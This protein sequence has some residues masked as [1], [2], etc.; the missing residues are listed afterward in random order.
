MGVSCKVLNAATI[1]IFGVIFW[2]AICPAADVSFIVLG[3]LHYDKLE[4]HDMDWLKNKWV[5][6]D[7]YR[8]VTQEYVVYT[9]KNWDKLMKALGRRI[10]G[11][12]G[13][14]KGIVQLGD[15]M[16]GLAGNPEMVKKMEFG[17]IKAIEEPNFQ[18]RWI[19]VKGNHDGWRKGQG[20]AEAYKEIMVPFRNKQMGIADGGTSF[21]YRAGDIEFF[22]PDSEMELN[23]LID[24]LEKG[25]AESNAKFKFVAMHAPVI[26]V[27]GRCWDI[28][29]IKDMKA[30]AQSQE[31]LLGLLARN[32][33]IVLC[34]HLHRYSVV[35]RDTGRGPVIQVML[36]SVIRDSN[37]PGPYWY[38]RQFGPELVDMEPDFA[39]ATQQQR[40][41][42][43]RQEM[44]YVTDFRL[45]DFPGYAVLTI[46]RE[47]ICLKMY[48]GVTDTVQEEVDLSQMLQKAS[49]AHVLPKN[50]PLR[51]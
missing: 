34:A 10:K 36:N 11:N 27:T 29:G 37:S 18:V 13:Q 24:F 45:A 20:E 9:A 46:K 30:R 50:H 40:K 5:N 7:D 15:F 35:R 28:F 33:A 6:P 4:F 26:P 17:T 31:R 43:L 44:K 16:E 19:L 21:R 39:P 41:Q 48:R 2:A 23:T 12:G 47:R 8:Q 49:P 32:E 38:T 51:D 14:V 42:V 22:C 25:L 1:G 3:D